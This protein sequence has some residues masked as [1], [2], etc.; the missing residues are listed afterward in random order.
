MTVLCVRSPGLI[1]L[2]VASIHFPNNVVLY[3]LKSQGN[4]SFLT[5]PNHPLAQS[6][7]LPHAFPGCVFLSSSR[8]GCPD[9]VFFVP[10]SGQ[11]QP[12]THVGSPGSCKLR[13]LLGLPSCV[14]GTS[15]LCQWKCLSWR[16]GRWGRWFQNR[17]RKWPKSKSIIDC[18]HKT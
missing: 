14:L 17:K 11:S 12:R 5:A 6:L 15:E 3:P 2:Q 8:P 7:S 10:L 16:R 13:G 1:Y 4:L 9:G 18:F